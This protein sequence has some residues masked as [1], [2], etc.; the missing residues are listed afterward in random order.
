MPVRALMR[1]VN[2]SFFFRLF[3]QVLAASTLL[4]A[5]GLTRP[6]ERFLSATANLS[7]AGHQI[8]LN[9]SANRDFMPI[10]DEDSSRLLLMV[11]LSETHDA[12]FP[13]WLTPHQFWAYHG[14]Q[15]WSGYLGE[16]RPLSQSVI[17]CCARN[18]P[19]WT[20]GDKI[21]V[22]VGVLDYSSRLHVMR[23]NDVVITGSF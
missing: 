9:C 17:I 16:I 10:Q 12:S 2:T 21:D 19:Y 6:D 15:E 1:Q 8:E 13:D 14:K 4:S 18:G 22:V 3:T 20:V 5:C 11:T 23:V 7:I